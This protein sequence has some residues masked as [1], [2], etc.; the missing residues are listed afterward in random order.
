[1]EIKLKEGLDVETKLKQDQS[2]L[3]L[4]LITKQQEYKELE[5]KF[6]RIQEDMEI[7]LNEGLDVET[8]LK[9]DQSNLHLSLI[10]KEQKYKELEERFNRIQ[11]DMEM[12]ITENWDMETKIRESMDM[13]I[14]INKSIRIQQAKYKECKMELDHIFKILN[15][16]IW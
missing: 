2:N 15:V 5:E 14:I 7:K 9:Q 16:R 4:S 11:E 3:R 1:M 6:S 13:E 10:T 8:K 12:K